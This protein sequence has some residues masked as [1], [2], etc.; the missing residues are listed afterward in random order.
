M[1][2][3]QALPVQRHWPGIGAKIACVG[4]AAGIVLRVVQMLFFFDYDAGFATDNGLFSWMSVAVVCVA[5]AVGCFFSFKTETLGEFGPR[6]NVS[7]GVASFLSGA[8]LLLSGALQT[9]D[10]VRFL[11]TGVSSYD[12]SERGIIHV[13]FFCMCFLFGLFLFVVGAGC[14]RGKDPFSK[15]PLMHLVGVLWGVSY[16]L[17]IYVFYAKSPSLTENIFAV[18]GGACLLLGLFYQSE[19][20]IG[21]SSLRAAKRLYLFGLFAVTLTITY[22]FSNLTLRLLGKRYVGEIHPI[23]QLGC[24]GAGLFLLVFL[25]TFRPVVVESGK[26]FRKE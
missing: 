21:M 22:A 3:E 2:N 20:V 17:L 6:R 1:N 10:Y 15:A 16:L 7:L 18:A 24:L 19:L 11:R 8:M 14:F 26:R 23:I 12:A 5:A 25:M 13:L 4:I 9:A